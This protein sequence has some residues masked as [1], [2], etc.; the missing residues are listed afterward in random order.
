MQLT[1]GA[2]SFGVANYRLSRRL[3]IVVSVSRSLVS[4]GFITFFELTTGSKT[5]LC[6]YRYSL[7]THSSSLP[8]TQQWHDDKDVSEYL[9]S[10]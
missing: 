7:K 9:L 2:L 8:L 6:N 3:V 5:Y 1:S 4:V 10:L